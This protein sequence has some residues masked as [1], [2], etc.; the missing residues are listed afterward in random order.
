MCCGDQEATAKIDEYARGMI[1]GTGSTLFEELGLYYIGPMD[2][3]NLDNLVGILQ[4]RHA[5][6]GHC[7]VPATGL[8]CS[9]AFLDLQ[10]RLSCCRTPLR[11]PILYLQTHGE[12]MTDDGGC[13]ER[14]QQIFSRRKSC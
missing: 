14:K 1:S 12:V 11:H 7:P 13:F 3:H 5:L 6:H 10:M 9:F 4:G 2:G 8:S